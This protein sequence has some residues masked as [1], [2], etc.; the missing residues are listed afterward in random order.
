MRSE[1]QMQAG[2]MRQT[3]NFFFGLNDTKDIQLQ[4][5]HEQSSWIFAQFSQYEWECYL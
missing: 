4:E 5:N 2:N 1:N 3:F